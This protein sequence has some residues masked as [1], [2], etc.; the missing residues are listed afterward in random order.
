VLHVPADAV[1]DLAEERDLKWDFLLLCLAGYVLTSVGRVHQLFPALELAHPAMVTGILGTAIY[2]LDLREERRAYHLLVPT[3]K[4]LVL[5]FIWMV[6]SVPGA[7]RPGASFDLVFGNFIKTVLMYVVVAGGVRGLRDIER[8]MLAYLIGA[9]LYAAVVLTRFDVGSGDAWRLGHLYYYDANDFAT[10]VVTAMPFSLFFLHAGRGPS[11]RW[12]AAIGLALL[13]LGLVR[14]GSRGGF[15]ALSA[16]ALFILLRYS[17]IALRWRLSAAALVG[18]V[19]LGTASAQYWDQMG[20][21]LSDTDYNRTEETG[22]L[23]IWS[24]GIGYMLQDP[25]LGL[26]PDN[27][28]AAEGT[29]SP[30]ADRQQYGIGVRW[31]AAHNSFVQAGAELGVPGLA[32]F[33]AIIVSAFAALRRSGRSERALAEPGECQSHLT[34]AMTASLLGFVVGSFFLSLAYSEMLYTLVALAIGLQKVTTQLQ[35]ESG[36]K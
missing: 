33:V 31:N 22:R 35:R 36:V 29:L 9:V 18:V 16:V 24:R 17:A 21:I 7:L 11:V 19:L 23:Q 10:F 30:L 3:T 32:L 25:I 1:A 5:F 4:L 6:L 27:F 14:S 2:L 12:L 15:I 8:L 28:A 26:G 13:T 34:P 20:T